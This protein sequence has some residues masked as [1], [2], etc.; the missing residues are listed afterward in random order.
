MYTIMQINMKLPFVS[1]SYK[2]VILSSGI[3]IK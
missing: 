1:F 2:I 3:F